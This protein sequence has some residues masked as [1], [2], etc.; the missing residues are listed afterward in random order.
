MGKSLSKINYLFIYYLFL[1]K[2][3]EF[4]SKITWPWSFLCLKILEKNSAFLTEIELF[5]F[6]IFSCVSLGKLYLKKKVFVLNYLIYCQLCLKHLFYS[7][8]VYKL[9][10]AIPPLVPDIYN[11]HSF[12]FALDQFTMVLLIV[13]GW[14]NKN[15]A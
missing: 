12:S 9:S 3:T 13:E 11:L 14:G 10:T 7:I 4:S 5:K 6:S 2:L 15:D 8:H 1:K